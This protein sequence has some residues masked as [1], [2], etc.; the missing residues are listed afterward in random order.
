MN[1]ATLGK[2]GK[3]QDLVKAL[4]REGEAGLGCQLC[5]VLAAACACCQLYLSVCLSVRGVPAWTAE[6]PASLLLSVV[7]L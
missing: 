6:A 5:L 7:Q 2:G 1:P 4:P 3:E